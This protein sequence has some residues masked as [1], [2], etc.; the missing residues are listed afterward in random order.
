[1]ALR[2]SIAWPACDF[3]QEKRAPYF[4]QLGPFRLLCRIFVAYPYL[5]R[6]FVSGATNYFR[7]NSPEQ[8]KSEMADAKS[9][10]G[11]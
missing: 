5:G 6:S 9:P 4:P 3:A 1:M 10:R 11:T 8:L 2:S 7:R